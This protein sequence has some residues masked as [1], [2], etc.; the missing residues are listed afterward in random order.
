[1]LYTVV[2]VGCCLQEHDLLKSEGLESIDN[3]MVQ[4]ALEATVGEDGSGSTV[5]VHAL[6][7]EHVLPCIVKGYCFHC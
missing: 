4:K 5:C 7:V 2:C 3:K 6:I 1:M